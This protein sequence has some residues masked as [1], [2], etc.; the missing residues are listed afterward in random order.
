MTSHNRPEAVVF[1]GADVVLEVGEDGVH[2]RMYRA[3]VLEGLTCVD[4]DHSALVHHGF[5]ERRGQLR[6]ERFEVHA[7]LF[8]CFV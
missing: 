5:Q 8:E 6:Q 7:D 1:D 3:E 2:F 4:T